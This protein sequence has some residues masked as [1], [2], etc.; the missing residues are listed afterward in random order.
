MTIGTSNS[1]QL[2]FIK[3]T[4]AGTTPTSPAMKKLRFKG[5]SLNSNNSTIESQ[6]IRDD[7]ATADLVLVDQSNSGEIMMEVS[8][9]DLDEFILAGL[10]SDDDWTSVD[11]SGETTIAATAS[12]FTDSGDGFV[13]AGLEL[14]QFIYISGFS[15]TDI[16]GYYRITSLAVGEIETYPVPPA[17]ETAGQSVTYVG[18]TAHTGKLDRSYTIEKYHSG[19]N[20]AVYQYFRGMR[21]ATM[22]QTLNIGSIA[23]M[24]FNFL[25]ETSE[26]TG[27]R[28]AG[29][30]ETAPGTNAIMNS[31]SNVTSI[32]AVGGGIT[33]ALQFTQLSLNY[34]N[35]LRELK[36]I[37]TLGSIDIR[38]GTV[39]AEATINPYFENKEILESFLANN[40]FVLSW[41][42]LASDG[43]GYIFSLPN[44]KFVNQNLAAGAKDTDMIVDTSVRAILADG[45]TAAM[46]VDRFTP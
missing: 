22:S 21:V 15:N 33:T 20:P 19:V 9:D 45:N 1:T 25:G 35:A 38:P 3:E 34:D 24:T 4:T 10:Y 5:E 26:V 23:E 39:N 27:T 36:A 13:S 12:G 37:G 40:S 8:G 2:S 6:E 18:S 16:D 30:T 43:Y 44:V 7:R 17:T 14:G 41:Q 42:L 11:N 29:R 28:V 46:R 32:V 31:V